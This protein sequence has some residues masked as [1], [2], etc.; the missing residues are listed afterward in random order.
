MSD[1]RCIIVGGGDFDP[2]L[3][4]ERRAG[5]LLIA[6]DIGVSI[7]RAAA[8]YTDFRRVVFILKQ[9]LIK[10]WLLFYKLMMLCRFLINMALPKLNN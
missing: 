4:P 7:E 3:L 9:L 8:V 5:E 1:K 2:A 10:S 6:A